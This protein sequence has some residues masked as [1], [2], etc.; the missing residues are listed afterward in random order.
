MAANSEVSGLDAV[1]DTETPMKVVPV[2][3][4]GVCIMHSLWDAD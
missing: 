1:A 2:D 4:E 3:F